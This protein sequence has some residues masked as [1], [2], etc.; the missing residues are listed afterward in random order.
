MERRP[1]HPRMTKQ[2]YYVPI[3]S[4]FTDGYDVDVIVGYV[5]LV[6]FHLNYGVLHELSALDQVTKVGGYDD[7]DAIFSVGQDRLRIS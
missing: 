5:V 6:R 4:H 2:N 7:L 1:K 3:H